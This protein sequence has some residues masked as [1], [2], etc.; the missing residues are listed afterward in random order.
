M[1]ID[2][3][4]FNKNIN[5]LQED[6]AEFIPG[7]QGWI[8]NQKIINITY[9]IHRIKDK[10]HTIIN[11]HRKSTEQNPNPIHGKTLKL[12]IEVSLIKDIY[13]EPTMIIL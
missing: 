11:K 6:Q 2:V 7:T 13:E 1:N 5:R 12:R 10:N 4:L 9:Y 8:N 3:K